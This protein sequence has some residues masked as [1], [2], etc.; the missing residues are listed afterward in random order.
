MDNITWI[1]DIS[2]N[3]EGSLEK[4]YKHII[5]AKKAGATIAKFQHW[6]TE[7]FIN[8]EAFENLKLGHQK[9]WGSVYDVYKKYEMP[10]E[11]IP[12]LKKCCD[13]N[14]IEF[15]LSEYDLESFDYTN[16]FVKRIKIGSGDINY[17][18]MLKKANKTGK[19]KLVGIGA[20]SYMDIY[21]L[22][23]RLKGEYI[24]FQC[25]TNYSNDNENIKN[26]N[27]LVIKGDCHD[28]SYYMKGLSDHTKSDIP[29][30][31]SISLGVR[32]IERHFK[33]DDNSSPDS[34]F[35]LNSKEWKRMLKIGNDT[36]LALGDG[37][38]KIEDNEKETRIIQRRDPRNGLRPDLTYKGNDID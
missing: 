33:I 15:M 8:K 21:N 22:R 38:K 36:L 1:A 28:S 12:K 3:H 26:L 2:S 6:V 34:K 9:D 5:E 19:Q 7:R 37:E 14:K 29:I 18:P 35:S 16:Q 17:L 27:L 11:W 31:S 30:I 25:N 10:L 20:S 23:Y 4:A 24:L 32:Y 13:D